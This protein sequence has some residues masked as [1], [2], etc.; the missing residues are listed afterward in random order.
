MNP[1]DV[2]K[3]GHRT[4][5]KTLDGLPEAD[6]QTPGVV[7]DWSVKDVVAHLASH[8]Q[9]L[10]EIL[11]SLLG[12]AATPTLDRF[13]QGTAAFNDP[14]VERRRAMTVA[15]LQAE[16]ADAHAQSL[17]LLPQLPDEVRRRAGTLPWYGAAYDLEDYICYGCYGHKREHAAQIDGYRSKLGR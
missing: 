7:G 17:V 4:V 12:E 2:L 1:L 13:K 6:W 16:L 5:L 9:V 8:E 15:D 3:Y 10:V 14:E 11:Q